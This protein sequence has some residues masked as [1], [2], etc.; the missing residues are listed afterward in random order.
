MLFLFLKTMDWLTPTP[1]PVSPRLLAR[2]K[3]MQKPVDNQPHV[4]ESSHTP[5]TMD[6]NHDKVIRH[7]SDEPES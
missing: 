7:A 6:V 5:T 1:G 3:R 2:M 4:W